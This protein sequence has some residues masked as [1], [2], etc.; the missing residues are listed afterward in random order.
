M[1]AP[2]RA[3]PAFPEFVGL[4]A[5]MIGVTA[6]AIDNLLPAF[7]PIRDEF[8]LRDPND[9]QLL[10][11]VYMIAFAL[12]QAVYGTISDIVGRRP[13]VLVGLVIF[14]AGGV[15]AIV[16]PTY[17]ILLVARVIQGIGTAAARVLAVAIVRD[18]HEGRDMARV[19]SL[20]MMVFLMVP[21]VAPAMGSALLLVGGWR[22]I[23]VSM[24]VLALALGIWFSL[25][26]PETLAPEDRLPLSG[27]RIADALRLTVTTRRSFGYATAIGFMLGALMAYIGSAQ[28]ILETTVYGLGPAFTLYFGAVAAVQGLASLT[29]ARFVVRVGMRRLSHAGLVGFLGLAASLLV[30]AL[31]SGGRPPLL[32]FMG[33]LAALFYLFSFIVSNFNALAML[34]LGAVAGTASSFI[35][36]YT[37]LIGAIT[38]LLVARAFDGGITPLVAG[39]CILGSLS[40]A[41]VLW[42]E[43]GRLFAGSPA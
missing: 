3:A 15:L 6:F 12:A 31:L 39:F 26:M 1:L 20:V 22:A 16:A 5:L 18:R 41:A 7:D 35:G 27:R 34:P 32:L 42:A 23:F 17:E 24:L 11:Y 38:G 40:L 2:A 14:A 4:I 8:R 36:A 19:M 37:T 9:A 43:R 25:R 30:A 28:Q 33:L 10:I 13:V 29:N 21:V